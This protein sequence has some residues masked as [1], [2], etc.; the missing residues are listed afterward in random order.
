MAKYLI[1]E[2]QKS[3]DGTIAVPPI[4]TADSLNAARSTFYSLCAVAAIS[5]VPVHTIVLLNDVGQ[6]I[7][8]ESFNH[9][10]ENEEI[11]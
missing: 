10:D 6:E 1:I 8:M 5:A 7:G 4:T 9:V 3:A 2:V 11:E